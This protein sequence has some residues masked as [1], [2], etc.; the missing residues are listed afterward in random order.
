[1]VSVYHMNLHA[2]K[3]SGLDFDTNVAKGDSG[4]VAAL[5]GD[6][7]F[8]DIAWLSLESPRS[9]PGRISDASSYNCE[10]CHICSTDPA[11]TLQCPTDQNGLSAGTAAKS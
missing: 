11:E 1:M 6:P 4:A 5:P 3:S 10:A 7:V 2:I 9:Q 8:S